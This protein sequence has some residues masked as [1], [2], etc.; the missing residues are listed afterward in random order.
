MNNFKLYVCDNSAVA[1]RINEVPYN[2]HFF[3]TN[4]EVF[5]ICHE[6]FVHFTSFLL[7]IDFCFRELRKCLTKKFLLK[8][9]EIQFLDEFEQLIF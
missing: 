7:P 9:Q 2:S 8:G 4:E 3:R 1:N 6:C 5:I